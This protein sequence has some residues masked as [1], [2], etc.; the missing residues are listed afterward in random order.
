MN[1]ND[2]FNAALRSQLGVNGLNILTSVTFL[3]VSLFILVI[4][5]FVVAMCSFSSKSA[6]KSFNLSVP[7]GTTRKS[8]VATIH[9]PDGNIQIENKTYMRELKI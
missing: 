8:E 5:C 9:V 3:F 1:R 4:G 2:V 6:S 7:S